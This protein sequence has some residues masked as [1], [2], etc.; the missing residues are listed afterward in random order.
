MV[1]KPENSVLATPITLAITGHRD[2]ADSKLI[3]AT[4]SEAIDIIEKNFPNTP[5]QAL[6]ALAEGADRLFAQVALDRGIPLDVILPMPRE[7]YRDDFPD[8]LDEFDGLIS[9]ARHVGTLPFVSGNNPQ[10]IASPGDARNLQYALVGWHLV[11]HAQILVAAWDGTP[12]RGMGGTAQVVN[13][14]LTGVFQDEG[15]AEINAN[16]AIPVTSPIDKHEVGLV[17]WIY[18]KRSSNKEMTQ[19]RQPMIQWA[20]K[21]DCWTNRLLDGKAVRHGEAFRHLESLDQFNQE[22]HKLS[23]EQVQLIKDKINRDNIARESAVV[24]RIYG[25]HLAADTIA[26]SNMQDVRGHFRIIFWIAGFMTIIFEI[27]AHVWPFWFVLFIYLVLIGV[28]GTIIHRLRHTEAHERS[29][30][31]RLLS[32]GLRVQTFWAA[33]GLSDLVSTYYMRRH[34]HALQWIR[35]ALSGTLPVLPDNPAINLDQVK[36][37]WV[38]DQRKYFEDSVLRRQRVVKTLLRLS[39][40]CYSLAILF[41]VVVFVA[42]LP[43][44][45]QFSESESTFKEWI[46]V[47]LGLLPAVSGLLASYIEFAGYKDDIREHSRMATLFGIG[48]SAIN[49][50]INTKVDDKSLLRFQKIV[51]DL[52]IEAMR[53]QADWALLHKSRELEIPKG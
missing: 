3:S 7:L 13:A 25:Q 51:R 49:S 46:I 26:N 17:C 23:S 42:S 20:D 14:R 19:V 35:T 11:N 18:T 24:R 28:I 33:S 21:P 52:G 48:G 36:S 5:L 45:N 6:S 37:L 39:T 44:L 30:N 41:A 1:T 50:L 10:K 38:E 53:E 29:V 9:K 47:L 40:W 15:F 22:L 43:I 31:W 12:A 16:D 2:P 27:W 34:G 32:E 8:S 4:I